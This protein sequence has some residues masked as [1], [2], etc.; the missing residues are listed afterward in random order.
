MKLNESIKNLIPVS[1][2]RLPYKI[3]SA[4]FFIPDSAYVDKY[5]HHEYFVHYGLFAGLKY[6]RASYYSSLLPKIIGSYEEQIQPWLTN[7]NDKYDYILNIGCAEGYYAVGLALLYPKIKIYA[8]DI[9]PQARYLCQQLANLNRVK[10]IVIKDKFT[11]DEKLLKK[12]RVLIVCDIEGEEINVLNPDKYPLLKRVDLIIE[13]H[14]YMWPCSKILIN[15]Y[16]NTHRV[17]IAKDR[18]HNKS[19]YPLIAKFPDRIASTMLDEKRPVSNMSW[20]K[21][22]HD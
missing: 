2:R 4:L 12:T 6:L 13:C 14:D 1:L 7:L 10:N 9:N 17:K 5:L 19:K 20:I 11:G 15:R 16:K 22:T 18:S 8:Y 3:F 21:L